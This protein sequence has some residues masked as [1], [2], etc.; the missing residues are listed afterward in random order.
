MKLS[1]M[2]LFLGLTQG[3]A[4]SYIEE[5]FADDDTCAPESSVAL[6]TFEADT[7]NSCNGYDGEYSII[8]GCSA[9]KMVEEY[10]NEDSSCAVIEK[11]YVYPAGE[12]VFDYEEA[13][14]KYYYVVTFTR[15]YADMLYFRGK[16]NDASVRI[17]APEDIFYY[18]AS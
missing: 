14:V 1:M 13:G 16:N 18:Y 9:E 4:C 5:A 12:C 17:F 6:K 7:M 3:Q 8:T 2:A 15:F 11:E 10:Y